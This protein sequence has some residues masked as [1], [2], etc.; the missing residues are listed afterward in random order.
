MEY[1]RID[2]SLYELT[3]EFLGESLVAFKKSRPR[4]TK[5]VTIAT[6]TL[7]FLAIIQKNVCFVLFCDHFV[8][9]FFSMSGWRSPG[10]F[11][12]LY[13]GFGVSVCGIIGYRGLQ[14][15]TF[16]TITGG[17]KTCENL[18]FWAQHLADLP[19]TK[20]YKYIYKR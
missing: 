17:W 3:Y 7:K 13:T 2:V 19:S 5:N 9:I 8:S 11:F 4:P 16:D 10:G 14:L 18:L 15:G 6:E 12:A 20:P 1:S